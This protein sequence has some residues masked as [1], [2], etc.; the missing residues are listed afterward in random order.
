[1]ASINWKT[2]QNKTPIT[3]FEELNYN[4]PWTEFQRRLKQ[5]YDLTKGGISIFGI[6]P[7]AQDR[8]MRDIKKMFDIEIKKYQLYQEARMRGGK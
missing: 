7:E 4:M 5:K 8:K 1:M 2:F 6:S 3:G